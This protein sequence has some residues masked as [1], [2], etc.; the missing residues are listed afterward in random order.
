MW[1]I[2]SVIHSFAKQRMSS[3]L[4][5]SETIDKRDSSYKS[6]IMQ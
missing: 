3:K 6:G 5:F 1:L 4:F 2:H